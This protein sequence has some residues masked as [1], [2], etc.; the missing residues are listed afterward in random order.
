[1]IL[2][3]KLF[4]RLLGGGDYPNDLIFIDVRSQAELSQGVIEGALLMP[5]NEL[6]ASVET[7]VPNKNTSVVV[8]CASGIRSLSAKNMMQKLGYTQVKNGINTNQIT[9]KTGKA[10]CQP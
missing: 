10:I 4:N 1:M 7:K 3:S 8:Y 5:L 6:V 9:K 2:F